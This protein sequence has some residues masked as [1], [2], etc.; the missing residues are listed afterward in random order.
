[1][2]VMRVSESFLSSSSRSCGIRGRR[3]AKSNTQ[4]G[5][6]LMLRRV[7]EASASD[8]L[9]GSCRVQLT[10]MCSPCRLS[11]QGWGQNGPA[12]HFCIGSL[13]GHD[14]ACGGQLKLVGE[15]AASRRVGALGHSAGRAQDNRLVIRQR[16]ARHDALCCGASVVVHLSGRALKLTAV[17]CRSYGRKGADGTARA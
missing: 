11:K 15:K 4:L 8:A 6:S 14:R 5:Q 9:A 17:S 13:P 7:T 12:F 1:M 10:L 2:S 3:A 16:N